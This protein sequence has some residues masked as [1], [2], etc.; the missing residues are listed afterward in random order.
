MIRVERKGS[1]RLSVILNNDNSTT[2]RNRH[3]HLLLLPSQKNHDLWICHPQHLTD[4]EGVLAKQQRG[5]EVVNYHY[6]DSSM[7]PELLLSESLLE[8]SLNPDCPFASFHPLL[9]FEPWSSSDAC[10]NSC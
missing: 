3:H 4:V 8:R 6:L 5:Q 2:I 1:D 10:F 7:L 9:L